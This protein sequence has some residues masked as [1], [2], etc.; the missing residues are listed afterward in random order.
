MAAG[1][2]ARLAGHASPAYDG[3]ALA[4]A[5][6]LFGGN[7]RMLSTPLNA[8]P[9]PSPTQGRAAL[10]RLFGLDRP[11]HCFTMEPHRWSVFHEPQITGGLV[12][13]LSDGPAARCQART[14]ALL[15]AAFRCAGRSCERLERQDIAHALAEAELRLDNGARIDILVELGFDDGSCAGAVIEAK[16]GADL[17]ANQLQ[18][19][20]HHSEERA[21]WC[22]EDTVLLVI[23]PHPRDLCAKVLADNSEWTVQSWW[24]LLDAFERELSPADDC[25]DFARFRRTIWERAYR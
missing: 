3:A 5:V 20:Q 1:D 18:C 6:R 9:P 4:R 10:S 19:Y 21:G 8:L 7:E 16:F 13:F 12:H 2:I 23:A 11:G 25:E 22:P 24:T 17:S 15:R 14:L